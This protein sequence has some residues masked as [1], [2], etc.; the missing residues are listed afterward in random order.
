MS[1]PLAGND[2][3]SVVTGIQSITASTTISGNHSLLANEISALVDT[4]LPH[5]WL[6]LAACQAFEVAF[7]L[8]WD[9]STDLYLVNDT[10]HQQL[11]TL[12]PTVTFTLGSSTPQSKSV[13][14]TLPYGAFDLQAASPIYPKGTNYF[15]LRRA[16]SEYQY[17]LGR[18]FFQEA[19]LI[20]DY[21]KSNFSISQAQFPANANLTIVTIDH[22][23]HPQV[24][25]TASPKL[26]RPAIAGIAIGSS[27]V[28]LLLCMIAFFTIRKFRPQRQR[29]A[30]QPTSTD[31][32]VRCK[33]KGDW[34]SSPSNASARSNPAIPVKDS[35]AHNAGELDG[36]QTYYPLP[37]NTSPTV[38]SGAGMIAPSNSLRQ[39]LVGSPTA[40]ELP[41]TPHEM[42]HKAPAKSKHISELPADA[43]RVGDRKI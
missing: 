33:E 25:D 26:S 4:T 7:G 34:P 27:V 23:P 12:Q 16:S 13:N 22:S 36:T 8:T 9:S 19:Y 35:D 2:S 31:S 40:K 42:I 18:A 29:A 30:H 39:E 41:P 43:V 10:V 32:I 3:T 1:F 37:T 15:P 20:V 38:A 11:K 28:L 6:P 24:A 5:I 21:E 17:T 14:I